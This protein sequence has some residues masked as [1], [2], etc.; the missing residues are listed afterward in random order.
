MTLEDYKQLIAEYMDEGEM[1]YLVVGDGET[2]LDE[3]R[4]LVMG[5]PIILDIK[6][7]PIAQ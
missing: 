6:G 1:I 5:D 4:K 2:Q 7:Q 3:V